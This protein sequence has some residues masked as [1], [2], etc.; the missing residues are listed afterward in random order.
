MFSVGQKGIHSKRGQEPETCSVNG[1]DGEI[2]TTL[3]N[4]RRRCQYNVVG[5]RSHVSGQELARQLQHQS[6]QN[7]QAS[8]VIQENCLKLEHS[9]L[10]WIKS[11][12][13]KC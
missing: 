12:R 9:E 2:V 3:A 6:Y 4:C 11:L 8:S 7:L 13:V 5:K 10:F 1:G